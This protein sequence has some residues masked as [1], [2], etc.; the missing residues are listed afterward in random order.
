MTITKERMLDVLGRA[1]GNKTKAAAMLGIPR[2][3]F[4]DRLAA[5]L[6]TAETYERRLEIENT[7]LKRRIK[8]VEDHILELEDTIGTL[9]AP[10]RRK[11]KAAP[12]VKEAYPPSEEY[13]LQLS[14]I[15]FGEVIDPAAVAGGFNGYDKEIAARRL[16]ELFDEFEDFAPPEA[17]VVLV[18]GGDM[19]SGTIHDDLAAT[20]DGTPHECVLELADLISP[21]I[22]RLA[23]THAVRIAAVMGNHGR[24]VTKPFNKAMHSV[25]W[26]WLLYKVLARD[27][28]DLTNVEWDIPDGADA[29]VESCEKHYVIT[30]GDNIGTGSWRPNMLVRAAE[31]VARQYFVPIEAVILHHFHYAQ[32]IARPGVVVNGSLCGPSEFAANKRFP[33]TPPEQNMWIT[34]SRGI[35]TFRTVCLRQ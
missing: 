21:L 28:R 23:E 12:L 34:S 20:N 2:T 11:A 30:H 16:K 1:G 25:N 35:E 32:Y 9:T 19:F 31:N 15:H 5:A 29:L 17:D 4:G 3:T 6:G 18:L 13:W 10:V 8:Q 24:V 7:T 22:R 14:D 33:L 27:M 26:D